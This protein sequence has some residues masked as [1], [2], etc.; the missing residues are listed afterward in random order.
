MGLAEY[1]IVSQ[2]D[3]WGI[4]HDGSIANRYANK[5]AATLP[6]L[7]HWSAQRIADDAPTSNCRAASRAL[8]PLSTSATTRI[9]R[10]VEYP[11]AIV[12]P[13]AAK[14]TFESDLLA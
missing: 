11:L 4:L 13:A 10:S 12:P 8:S 7:D 5:Q 14:G 3:E 2:G 1:A 6:V 9:L